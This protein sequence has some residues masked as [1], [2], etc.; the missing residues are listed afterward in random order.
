MENDSSRAALRVREYGTSGPLVVA[1]TS[2][3]GAQPR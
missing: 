1:K 2:S 3:I